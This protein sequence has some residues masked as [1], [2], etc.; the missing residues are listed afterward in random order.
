MSQ[1]R[2]AGVGKRFG[3]RAV[4]DGDRWEQAGEQLAVV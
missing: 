4:E 1:L 2:F 3:D